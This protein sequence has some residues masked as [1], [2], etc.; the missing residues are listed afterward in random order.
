MSIRVHSAVIFADLGVVK[1]SLDA[2][3]GD[4]S[5]HFYFCFDAH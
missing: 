3:S 1:A 4:N 5:Y 2:T